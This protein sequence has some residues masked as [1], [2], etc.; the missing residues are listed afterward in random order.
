[1][2]TISITID[3]ALDDAARAEAERRGISKS[4]LIRRGLRHVLGDSEPAG[5]DSGN[6]LWVA[7]AGF[8]PEGVSVEPGEIDDV[9]YGS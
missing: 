8:G 7:L 5:L 2:K 4:E 9:L 6:D 3:E 1:M